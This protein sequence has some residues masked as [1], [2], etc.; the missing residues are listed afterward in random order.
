MNPSHPE[1]PRRAA[2][3]R[4]FTVPAKLTTTSH[5]TNPSVEIGASKDVETLYTHSSAS[6]IKFSTP[7]SSRPSSSSSARSPSTTT[8]GTLPWTS[9]T[10]RTLASGPLE[11]YRVPGSVSFLHSGALLH[12]ILP[13]SQCWCVDGVSKFTMRVLPETYYRIELP[14]KTPEDLV[15]VEEL[16][17]VLAKVLFYERT[18]CPFNRGIEES[19]PTVE[20][21]HER[22]VSR[23]ISVGPAK[24]WRRSG[25]YSWM[26]E[27]GRLGWEAGG[28]VGKE[29]EGGE[30]VSSEEVES[31]TETP[32]GSDLPP[33]VASTNIQT[34]VRPSRL[35]NMRSVTTPARLMPHALK[36]FSQI[37]IS[38][39]LDGTSEIAKLVDQP[40]LELAEF[41]TFQAIPTDMPPSP[42]D[43]SGGLE[44][45]EAHAQQRSEEP[46]DRGSPAED[47]RT[48]TREPDEPAPLTPAAMQSS[49]DHSSPPHRTPEPASDSYSHL[50]DVSADRP[51][52]AARDSS[53]GAHDPLPP[54]PS[55]ATCPKPEDDADPFA[56]IQ[57]RIRARRSIGSAPPTP[58]K[59]PT[60]PDP[61]TQP[62]QPRSALSPVSSASS[63][64]TSS[65]S[66]TVTARPN[67]H[68]HQTN[69]ASALVH[70]ACAVFLGPPA[71]LVAIMLKIAARLSADTLALGS[72]LIFQ[73]P[74]GSKRVPGSY[75]LE[76]LD[77]EDLDGEEREDG[78]DGQSGLD[79][80]ESRQA[81][82]V[83]AEQ[84]RDASEEDDDE[85]DFGVPLRSPVRLARLAR[86]DAAGFRGARSQGSVRER[87]GRQDG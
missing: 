57:S 46:E 26:P 78:Y 11:I 3:N 83:R 50:E 19:R 52:P 27:D 71:H 33:A 10:E 22:R 64:T 44:V 13:R 35:E 82:S 6:I 66:S 74:A 38:T 24:K 47:E 73:S 55:P 59:L 58:S 84:T 45:A 9:R 54:S 29:E 42:P 31:G 43:S 39:H 2:L 81:G 79:H 62:P 65:A 67:F 21:L 18:A 8:S 85:D 48:E 15:K 23:R 53:V 51:A 36:P 28:L 87:W 37:R 32:D 72:G 56:A 61:A 30:D 16:K 86:L 77:A 4:S 80:G 68:R 34:P 63:S 1:T 75:D 25:R 41:R 17:V 70:K 14:A 20:E 7:P 69:L 40:Q 5:P 76:S 49:P 60:S 12:A